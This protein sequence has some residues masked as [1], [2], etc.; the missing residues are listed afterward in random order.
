MK[1]LYPSS[2]FQKSFRSMSFIKWLIIASLF[3]FLGN[4]KAQ[5]SNQERPKL[6]L[7]LS[8]GGAKG[9]AHIGAI[10]V[11]EEAGLKFDYI[12]GTSMGS[13]IGGLYALG[14]HPDT[15][16]KIVGEQD[17]NTLM[18]D[19]IPRRFIPI[20]EKKNADRFIATFPIKRRKLQMKQGLYNGQLIESLLAHYTSQS[21]Q[22]HRFRDFSVPFICIGTDLEDGSSVVLDSGVL[23]KALRASMSIPSYFTPVQLNDRLLVD[24]GVV[25]NYPVADVKTMGADLI[26]GVDVQTGLHHPEQLNS[27]VKIIDQVTAFYRMDANKKGFEQT[28]IYI[29]PELGNFD[30]MS[31][32]DYDSIIN[33]GEQAARKAL[34][35]LKRLADSLN[36]L[37]PGLERELNAKPLDSVFVS[38]LQY[39]GLN[40]VSGSYLE[41]A[42]QIE[43][44]QWLKLHDLNQ[45]ILRAYGSGFF[46]VV[47]YHFLP[48]IESVVLVVEVKEAGSGILGAGIHFDSDYK[49]ALL[50]NA[51]YKNVL[52]KGSKLFIDVSF[53]ENPR[54]SG[55]YLI[56]RGQKPGFGLKITSFGLGFNQYDNNNI[57]DVFTTNQNKVAV[58]TQL[59]RKNTLQFR[60]GFE[61]EYIKLTSNLSPAISDEYNSYLT[62]FVNW[63]ADTYDRSSFPT[64]GI[65]FD[66]KG[67]F[68]VPV[69]QNWDED[70]LSNAWM[71]QMRFSQN[72]PLSQRSTFRSTINAGFTIKD[73]LPP[74]QHWFILG[75]QSSSNYYDGFIPFTGLR[76]IEEAGLY[77]LVGSFAWQY[78]IHRRFYLTLKWDLGFISVDIEDMMRNPQLISGFGLTAGYD[79]FIGP[80]EFSVMGSNVNNGMLT[81]LNIGYWF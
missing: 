71:F 42:L 67:K 19:K 75:G 70:L 81:F 74:P 79:S 29:K 72:S 61:Y 77:N 64:R 24:G 49:V 63:I 30:V 35:N 5:Q 21:Y 62:L 54:I 34:P 53:G 68:I 44:R 20:E 65:Q 51:T 16:V 50:L 73:N 57:I 31:F 4:L 58:F 23:H 14:Y 27:L 12:G 45:G 7:V 78:N 69:K 38:S 60:S 59:S 66:L 28:D 8:G 39:R 15:M 25:N 26:V 41:G 76:F 6:G 52:L 80:V 55:F 10:K 11:F 46:E 48:D 1:A 33:L 2:D 17:W 32:E 43:P 22:Y 37:G 47:T 40:D 18:A 9:F 36:Q 3:F 13:I 56:D